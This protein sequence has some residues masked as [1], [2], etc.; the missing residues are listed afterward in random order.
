MP[1]VP[2]WQSGCN[3]FQGMSIRIRHC[4]ECPKCRTRYLI[5]FTPYRNGAF[6]VR[7]GGGSSEEYTLYCFCDGAHLPNIW[8]WREAR[9]CE[10]SKAAHDR[11]YGTRDEI[12]AIT[13]QLQRNPSSDTAP[14]TAV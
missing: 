9:P 14:R 7:T 11:G 5:A 4:V 8:K 12:W 13:R 3:R 2:P 10:V 1:L 6:L